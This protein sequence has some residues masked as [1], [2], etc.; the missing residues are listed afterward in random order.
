[1]REIKTI[2][3]LGLGAM[4]NGIAHVAAQS[5]YK[6]HVYDVSEEFLNRGMTTIRKNLERGLKKG[7]ITTEEIDAIMS[8]ITP[9]TDL[10]K[11]SEG[12]DF[13]IEAVF[14]NIEVKVELFAHL[15]E[16]LPSD[17]IFASNTSSISL[18]LLGGSSGRP[19]NFIG[20]HFFNPVPVKNLVEIIRGL[21]TSDETYEIAKMLSSKFGK[22]YITAKDSPGFVVNR[23]LVPMLNE[24][25]F[26]VQEGLA[27]PEDIDKG[28]VLGTNMNMGPLA[29]LDLVG[30]DTALMVSNVFYEQFQDSKYRV[31]ELLKQ[32]VASKLLG[33]KTKRGF[34][35]YD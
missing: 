30:L 8:R 5:G 3:V 34:Y 18:S 11:A 6:T 29:L 32:M 7:R 24:A 21:L 22:E 27:T 1:M 31:P 9:F 28:M 23:I 12:V 25:V 33:R 16:V 26:A 10:T 19:E 2:L 20:M 15:N 35:T 13:V 14:E 4:G 17:I